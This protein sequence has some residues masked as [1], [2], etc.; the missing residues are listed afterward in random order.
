MALKKPLVIV[1][2]LVRQIATGDTL[3][4]AVTAIDVVSRQ[5]ANVGAIVICTPV[6][7]SANGSVDKAQADAAATSKVMGLM[8]DTSVAAG[9]SGYI[10]T[11]GIVS[12]TTGQWDAV[13]GTTGGLVANTSYWL[14]PTTAGKITA[15]AP[16]TAAQYVVHIGVALSTTELLLDV[17][18]AILL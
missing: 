7:A 15:T 14:D 4:A 12:A 2:G 18:A 11:D 13:A 8:R 6:Y 16:T 10:Q 3:D 9:D 1:D 5:N 17:H